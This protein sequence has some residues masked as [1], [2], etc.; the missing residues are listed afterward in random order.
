MSLLKQY[1]NCVWQK[2][3]KNKFMLFTEILAL[4][5]LLNSLVTIHSHFMEKSSLYALL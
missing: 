4:K 2:Q 3:E 5:I 1:N